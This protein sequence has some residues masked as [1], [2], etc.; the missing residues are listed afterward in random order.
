MLAPAEGAES[1]KKAIRNEKVSG[2]IPLGSTKKIRY[3]R[4]IS[5]PTG[6][7]E[8]AGK[9]QVQ[10]PEPTLEDFYAH[11][12]YLTDCVNR[13]EHGVAWH[14]MDESLRQRW[15]ACVRGAFDAWREQEHFLAQQRAKGNPRA[16]F[17]P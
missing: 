14:C 6:K 5:K 13:C 17:V 11:V 8:S 2:S 9:V 7:H 3:L 16:F 4:Q 15:R 12:M 10:P 1:A